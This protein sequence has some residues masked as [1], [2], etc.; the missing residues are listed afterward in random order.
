M[1]GDDDKRPWDRQDVE[2]TK[3]YRAFCAYR[4]MGADRTLAAVADKLYPLKSGEPRASKGQLPGHITRW[5][6]DHNWVERAASWDAHVDQQAQ[7][8]FVAEHI[9]RNR[10]H[11]TRAAAIQE[12]AL[13]RIEALLDS[14]S[15]KELGPLVRLYKEA[16]GIERDARRLADLD[17]SDSGNAVIEVVF[18][19]EG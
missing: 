16:V 11:A 8:A 3:A 15:A 14:A 9:A 17:D 6:A 1:A 18:G 12:K 13:E 5:S 7:A 2:S 19:L 10:D 4:D